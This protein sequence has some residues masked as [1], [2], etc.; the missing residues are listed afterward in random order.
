[1]KQLLDSAQSDNLELKRLLKDT[2]VER[3]FAVG[4]ASEMRDLIK[5]GRKSSCSMIII[6]DANF[7]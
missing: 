6:V 7:Q 1:M 3:E 4:S 2:E 5:I